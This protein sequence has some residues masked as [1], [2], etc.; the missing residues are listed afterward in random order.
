MTTGK[1]M[2]PV[3][4]PANQPVYAT[5]TTPGHWAGQG[6]ARVIETEERKVWSI[7]VENCSRKLDLAVMS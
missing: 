2:P 6:W 5:R 3:D 1:D 7:S 4:R